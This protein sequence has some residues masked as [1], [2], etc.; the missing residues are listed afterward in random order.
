MPIYANANKV[1]NLPLSDL[2]RQRDDEVSEIVDEL[3]DQDL[4]FLLLEIAQLL[5]GHREPQAVIQGLLQMLAERRRLVQGRIFMPNTKSGRL[6]MRYGL[7]PSLYDSANLDNRETAI[8]WTFKAGKVKLIPDIENETM[9]LGLSPVR[10]GL[11]SGKICFIAVPIF[12]S[13][14]VL[15]VLSVF[16][17]AHEKRHAI[18]DMDILRFA[19]AVIGQS[20]SIERRVA[21][22]TRSL[23]QTGRGIA[24]GILGNSVKLNEALKQTD[25]IASSDAP[26]MLLG[27]SGTGK[28]KFARMI[29]QQ[30][31]R[32]EGPF[33]CINCAAIPQALLESEL[34]GYEKGS[35]TG[36][37]QSRKGKIESADQGT[38]FLDEIGDLPIELQ[39]K[40]LRVIQ[41]RR[42]ERLGANSSIQVD[43]RIITAT[44]VDLQAAVNEGRFRLDLFYRLNV[45]PIFLP[46]LRERNGDVRIIALHFLNEL[47]H[48]YQ[49]NVTF[50]DGILDLME[51]FDWPGNIRQLAN[52]I[53]RAV[54][55]A[56]SRRIT[57]D[58]IEAILGQESSIVIAK[59]KPFEK[60]IGESLATADAK[61]EDDFNRPYMKVNEKE[62]QLIAS[63]IQKYHG[64]KT[65]AA[66]CLGMTVRQLRYRIEKLGIQI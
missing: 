19:A 62:S 6:E 56:E 24:H 15:G 14:S 40:L 64:N 16:G 28:E 51:S 23:R 25:Q 39:A 18:H 48:H 9:P 36:A 27:E 21:E 30:S 44:H 17:C 1:D 55:T 66:K 42:V 59:P 43:F 29:H 53:E 20:L 7:T 45:F 22:E 11:P 4:V 60:T 8:E 3:K 33:V 57:R 49:R 61:S 26:T 32:A 5:E 10:S 37:L 12:Q 52:V 13:E 2:G 46:P 58:Q 34:F 50:D 54:L 47:N 41:E 38:L 35:F 65:Y 31:K 63:A